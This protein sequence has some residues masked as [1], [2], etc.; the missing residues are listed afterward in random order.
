MLL[1]SLRP[2]LTHPYT[3][4]RFCLITFSFIGR[5]VRPVEVEAFLLESNPI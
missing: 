5:I 2:V 4:V 3:I 1:Y